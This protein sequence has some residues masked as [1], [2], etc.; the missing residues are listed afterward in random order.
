MK[1]VRSGPTP[2]NW[3]QKLSYGLTGRTRW[4]VVSAEKGCKET[5]AV[6]GRGRSAWNSL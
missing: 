6:G 4:P 3:C 1:A 2:G 5:G